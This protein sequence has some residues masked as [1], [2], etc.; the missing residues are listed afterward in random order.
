[1]HRLPETGFLRLP[2]IIGNPKASPPIPGVFPVGKSTWWAGVKSGKYPPAVKISDRCTAW[3]VEAILKLIETQH[4]MASE[5]SACA[6]GNASRFDRAAMPD[7]VAYYA[8]RASLRLIGRGRWRSAVCPFHDDTR[9][10]LRVNAETG[11][12]RCMV[13]NAKGGDVLAFHRARHGLS[14]QQAARDLGAWRTA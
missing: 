14:F 6:M 11:A 5:M 12:Y 13:C 2:Q 10:S 4:A 8:E 7:P 9:P 3:P 1:M